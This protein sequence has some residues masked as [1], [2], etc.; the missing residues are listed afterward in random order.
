MWLLLSMTTAPGG[1][2]W[3]TWSGAEPMVS[4]EVWD[5]LVIY[6]GIVLARNFRDRSSCP[7]ARHLRT[8]LTRWWK[9]LVGKGRRRRRSTR[10]SLEEG[11]RE[12][13][14]DI[15]GRTRKSP[16][17]K[18]LFSLPGMKRAA[19]RPRPKLLYLLCQWYF[20]H[21]SC[22]GRGRESQHAPPSLRNVT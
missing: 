16:A 17:R 20:I 14:S 2:C 4:I 1:C 3:T 6:R 21:N 10:K 5:I 13:S 8:E 22:A 11:G 15:R 18:A 19:P 7:F 9:F 12:P